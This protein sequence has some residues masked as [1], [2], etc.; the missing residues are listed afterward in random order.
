MGNVIASQ[1]MSLDGCSAGPNRGIKNP[2]GDGGHRLHEWISS[3]QGSDREVLED[4]DIPAGVVILGRNM[5]NE[6]EEPWGENPP[7]HVPVLV[8]THESKPEIVKEGGTTFTFVTSGIE[9]ALRQAHAI[10]GDQD[11]MIAG[12]ANTIQQYLE[13][14]LLDELR[15]HVVPVLFGP[16][17][18]LF[19][20]P[21]A[22]RIELERMQV[23][24][25]PGATHLR[26]RPR[27]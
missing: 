23:I 21:G 22:R 20:P 4:W 13:A 5:F 19:D 7:W 14:G 17:L 8:L 1:S 2:L 10:A 26:F 6:G 12:G 3:P 11:I 15:I 9:S 24:A 18:R 16:G 25:S 27:R